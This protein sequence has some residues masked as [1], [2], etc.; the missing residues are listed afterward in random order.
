MSQK[1]LTV[2]ARGR[3]EVE[4]VFVGFDGE[5]STASKEKQ[6]KN[7]LKSVY[8]LCLEEQIYII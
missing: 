5:S 2:L 7:V 3:L 4:D 1:A 8:L 6:N